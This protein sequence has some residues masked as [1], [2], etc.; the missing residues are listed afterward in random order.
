MQAII[1][2][3]LGPTNTK[4]S[5]IKA[6]SWVDSVTVSYNHALNVLDNHRAAADALCAKRGDGWRIVASASMPDGRGYA[7]TAEYDPE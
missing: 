3:F 4:G 1:T 7:F 6:T 2:K 5:R